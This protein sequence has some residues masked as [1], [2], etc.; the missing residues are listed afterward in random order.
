MFDDLNRDYF[1][2]PR[3][4]NRQFYDS[5]AHKFVEK[6][7][8]HNDV[9]GIFL[10]G[11]VSVPGVS[12]LDFIVVMKDRLSE[13][14]DQ[15]YS[16]DKFAED[17]RYIYNETQPFLLTE[18][19]FK[20]F[21][22]IFPTYHL[23]QIYGKK[24]TQNKPNKNEERL[25]NTLILIEICQNFYPVIFLKQL[26]SEKFNV[27]Y[28]LLVLNAFKFPLNLFMQTFD[29]NVDKWSE[30]NQDVVTLRENW[31][32]TTDHERYQ[33]MMDLLKRAAQIS[34]NLMDKLDCCIKNEFWEIDQE[35]L[36]K[37]NEKIVLSDKIYA[38]EFDSRTV[39][40]K[41]VCNYNNVGKWY[42]YL[43]LTFY[44]P[45]LKY[46]CEKGFVSKLIKK[47]LKTDDDLFFIKNHDL[48]E[49]M[50]CRVKLMN[51]HCSFY[52]NNDIK[53]NMVH[54]YYGYNPNPT[55]IKFYKKLLKPQYVLPKMLN[56]FMSKR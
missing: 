51:D 53:V 12:D 55:R 36:K 11:Q 26:A 54:T 4:F 8:S 19:V 33:N 48:L 1:N 44:L 9:L 49:K 35:K 16:I 6:Y 29:I 24:L 30:L 18:D 7:S 10:F 17:L 34:T 5:A 25:Y 15:N 39:L 37:I 56:S 32:S 3:F 13:K 27:R 31:F 40:D 22:K 38:S 45:V 41:M 47:K 50:K 43:P 14:L 23:N 28:S 2:N 46:S 21:W 52:K 42:S 20:D